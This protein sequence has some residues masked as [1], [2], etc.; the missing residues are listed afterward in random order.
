MAVA[1]ED[2]TVAFVMVRGVEEDRVGWLATEDN[3]E[4]VVVRGGVEDSTA[5]K[6]K[7][8]VQRQ[9]LHN[10]SKRHI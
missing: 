5:A 6:T 1:T 8:H 3:V 9:F 2:M 7:H 4:L 10:F